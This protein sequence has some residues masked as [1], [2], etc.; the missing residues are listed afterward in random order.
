MKC[1]A[2]YVKT[3]YWL[4]LD[5]II[6]MF[7]L[8]STFWMIGEQHFSKLA[9]ILVSIMARIVVWSSSYLPFEYYYSWTPATIYMNDNDF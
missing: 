5:S 7:V 9:Y 2:Y 6:T 8:F 4:L 3:M 1:S